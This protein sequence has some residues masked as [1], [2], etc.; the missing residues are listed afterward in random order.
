V[1]T[2]ARP[3]G[4]HRHRTRSNSADNNGCSVL[5]VSASPSA[6]QPFG[7]WVPP[8]ENL[9]FTTLPSSSFPRMTKTTIP[10]TTDMLAALEALDMVLGFDGS[11]IEDGGAETS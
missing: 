6:M 7:T 3:V 1:T 9:S 11:P 4:K 8:N 10:A 2:A 5:N